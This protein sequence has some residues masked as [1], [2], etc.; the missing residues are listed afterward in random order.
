L[1]KIVGKTCLEMLAI[2][3]AALVC[4]L[5]ANA[6][7]GD[8]VML[9]KSYFLVDVVVPPGEMAAGP[10]VKEGTMPGVSPTPPNNDETA[11][12]RDTVPPESNYSVPPAPNGEVCE[13]N[14]LPYRLPDDCVKVDEYGLQTACFDFVLQQH[15]AMPDSEGFIVFVDARTE[16]AYVEE[17]IPGA[18]HV[19]YYKQNRSLPAVLPRLRAAS[20]IFLYCS[21]GDCEDSKYLAGDLITEYGLPS[22]SI[23][24]YEGGMETWIAHGKPLREGRQP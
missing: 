11:S 7:N 6:I 2:C 4:G 16:E 12:H 14:P 10:V 23:Y 15:A 17:H 1:V 24:L 22:D 20:F 19:D 9:G 21:G 18:L 3:V 8:G 13:K 5:V